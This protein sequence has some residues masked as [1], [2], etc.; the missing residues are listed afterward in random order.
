MKK[1]IAIILCLMMTC[2][3]TQIAAGESLVYSVDD[4]NNR[5]TKFMAQ[6]P[7]INFVQGSFDY[8]S[9]SELAWLLLSREFNC[10]VFSMS[11]Q[12]IDVKSI[13]Q[14][15]YCADL[16]ESKII[17]DVIGRMHPVIQNQVVQDGKIMGIPTSISFSYI[18]VNSKTW[19]DMG[20]TASDIPS[21][22]QEL[23][24]F[25]NN[26][27]SRAE[28]EEN[29]NISVRSGWVPELYSES[30][31][32]QWL[33]GLLIDEY[34]LQAQYAGDELDF[35]SSNLGSLLEQI[36]LIGKRIYEAEAKPSQFASSEPHPLFETLSGTVFPTNSEYIM[37]LPYSEQL[38]SLMRADMNVVS[39]CS[40]TE[41]PTIAIGLAE[42]VCLSLSD[43]TQALLFIESSPLT[44]PNYKEALEMTLQNIDSLKQDLDKGKR[45]IKQ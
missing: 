37:F 10:D 33:T 19:S 16:S 32:I 2:V 25:L 18:Q 30:S 9:T 3:C 28:N 8:S 34:I 29:E 38:P 42:Q 17:S 14:K 40:Y 12:S 26:W 1:T 6:H 5:F 36:K 44:N 27:C 13:M 21:S 43:Y 4:R 45:S 39:V 23:L 7:E 35:T 41:L 22:F 15:G 11:T 24:D 31:Y 20:Y